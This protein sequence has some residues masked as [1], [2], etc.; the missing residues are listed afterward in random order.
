MLQTCLIWGR[1]E[2]PNFQEN[3]SP[4]FGTPTSESWDKMPFGYSSCGELEVKPHK[5][6]KVGTIASHINIRKIQH[7]EVLLVEVTIL[8]HK[9]AMRA[10]SLIK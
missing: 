2:H 10:P 7:Q 4:N 6:V 8:I 9:H 5:T 1:Y 3:K